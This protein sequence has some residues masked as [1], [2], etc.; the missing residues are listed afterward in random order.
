KATGIKEHANTRKPRR[1]S[2][3]ERIFCAPASSLERRG[4]SSFGRMCHDLPMITGAHLLLYSP[5]AEAD[6]AFFR[7]VLRFPWAD[8]GHRWLI[9]GL[10][11][12]ELAVHPT[13]GEPAGQALLESG[14]YLM[15]DDLQEVLRTLEAQGIPHTEVN[16]APWGTRTTIRLP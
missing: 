12:A 11:A 1:L 2:S 5:D 16:Q 7:D 15:C 8:A 14:L 6:R 10:P 9:F 13:D 3:P 4:R